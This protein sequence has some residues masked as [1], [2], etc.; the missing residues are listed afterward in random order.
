[1]KDFAGKLAVITGGGSGM[2]RELAL[3]LV[4]EGCDVAMCDM[5]A[6]NLQETAG[7][8]KEQAPQ[9][10][11][12]STHLCNVSEESQVVRFRDE[13]QQQHQRGHINLLFN[14]AGIG[15]GSSFIKDSREDWE[16]TFAVCWFGVYYNTRAFMPM[17]IA[18][19]EGHLINTSSVNGFW[20]SLGPDTSQTAYGAAKFAVKGFSEALINDLRL[21]APHVKVSVVMPGHIG[22][23]MGFNT[24]QVHGLADPTNL[25]PA[26]VDDTRRRI[27]ER[28]ID[29]T[30]LSDDEVRAL[31]LQGAENF[32]DLA[33]TTAT[34][35]ATV[36]LEGVRAEKWRILIGEDAAILD[37]LV[38]QDP[39]NAYTQEFMDTFTSQSPWLLGGN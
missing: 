17:L 8:C 4:S 38:R 30:N 36:I 32:R 34:A 21:N 35:A 11:V 7:L 23:S 18:S 5:I 1:M 25:S 2:G 20:A 29:V 33:P 6:N 39:E 28:G 13:V 27:A 37:D 3:Q 9:G 19:E 31:V 12:V 22:T 10:V 14:N 16:R 24:P 26:D 15:G